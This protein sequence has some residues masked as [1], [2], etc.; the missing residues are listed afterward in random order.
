VKAHQ[1]EMPIQTLI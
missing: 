1:R